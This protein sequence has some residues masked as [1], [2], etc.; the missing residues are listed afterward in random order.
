[1]TAGTRVGTAEPW[2]SWKRGKAG[3]EPRAGARELEHSTG[4]RDIR[5]LISA[6]LITPGTR[7]ERCAG[8]EHTLTTH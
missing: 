8:D 3:L 6:V 1:M 4:H 2:H 7:V 5:V